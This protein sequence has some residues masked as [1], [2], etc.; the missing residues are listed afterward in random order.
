[1]LFQVS[2]QL[3][4]VVHIKANPESISLQKGSP[5]KMLVWFLALLWAIVAGLPAGVVVVLVVVGPTLRPA[6][7]VVVGHAGPVARIPQVDTLVTTL[8]VISFILQYSMCVSSGSVQC[9]GKCL[10]AVYSSVLVIEEVWRQ[11]PIQTVVVYFWGK[12]AAPWDCVANKLIKAGRASII[13]Y[14]SW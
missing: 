1:M 2:V 5:G 9:T 8:P 13:Q 11:K 3:F 14:I 12:M 6:A 7:E 10:D 4:S